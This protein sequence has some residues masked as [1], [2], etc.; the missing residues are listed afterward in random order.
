MFFDEAFIAATARLESA[1][2]EVDAP[3]IPQALMV[4]PHNEIGSYLPQEKV[5]SASL[6]GAVAILGVRAF[7]NGCL[8]ELNA[9]LRTASGLGASIAIS[10][11]RALEVAVQG[12]LSEVH[13]EL[14][15]V[16]I[17]GDSVRAT[18]LLN[19]GRLRHEGVL[20]PSDE[21]RLVGLSG[22]LGSI[23]DGVM[24]FRQG[25][26][27]RVVPTGEF[28]LVTEW[29]AAGIDE[30]RARLSGNEIRAAGQRSKLLL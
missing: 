16:G 17:D 22:T 21:P 12:D 6:D 27:L 11:E 1:T 9:A 7:R 13:P 19:Y 15:R 18:N 30:S 24:Q 2:A 10:P 29:P 8:I 28:D 5:I 25:Y 23:Q 26:W 3:L 4:P 14:L 20:V